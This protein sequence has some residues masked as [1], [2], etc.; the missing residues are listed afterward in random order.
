MEWLEN[1]GKTLAP[2]GYPA[3]FVVFLGIVV[4]GIGES[5]K[6]FKSERNQKFARAISIAKIFF[7]F[8]V[9]F[10]LIVSYI[11]DSK[12]TNQPKLQDK[13]VSKQILSK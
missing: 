12:K 9:C 4:Y 7:M 13:T 1:L 10:V 3:L 5:E 6:L 2:L 11:S 8:I